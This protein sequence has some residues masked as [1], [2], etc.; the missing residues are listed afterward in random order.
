M[1]QSNHCGGVR[2]RIIEADDVTEAVERLFLEANKILPEH[3]CGD[4][5]YAAKAEASKTGRE[6]LETLAENLDAAKRLDIPICQDTGMAVVF[7]DIGWRVHVL[8]NLADAINEGVR[9]AYVGGKLRLSVVDDPIGERKNT[10]DNTPAVIHM[11]VADGEYEDKLV[12]TAVPKGFGSENMSAIKMFT[13]SATTDDIASF[14]TDTVKL[15]GA[16]PC[17]PIYIGVGVGSDFEGAAI[18]SKRALT[19]F[20]PSDNERTRQL[21]EKILHDVNEL[22]IGPQ[23]F[24]GTTTALGVHVLTAPTHIAGL[25]VAV[26]ICCHVCREKTAVL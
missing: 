18:L 8:G 17:P 21:E 12:I 26:N 5:K 10:G 23:G 7:V 15:A 19:V 4:L 20:A 14:V 11:R 25:P 24:G 9:R 6:V 2:I 13:P 22:D 16:N 3:V 1:E